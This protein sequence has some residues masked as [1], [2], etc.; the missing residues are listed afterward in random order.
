[1]NIYHDGN[2]ASPDCQLSWYA[3]VYCRCLERQSRLFLWTS[4]RWRERVR[5]A[6][7]RRQ[8]ERGRRKRRRVVSCSL[9]VWLKGGD[10]EQQRGGRQG[11]SQLEQR[12]RGIHREECVLCGCTRLPRWLTDWLCVFVCDRQRE[13]RTRGYHST[14]LD[15]FGITDRDHTRTKK[16]RIFHIFLKVVYYLFFPF[17]G[18]RV[19]RIQ[20]RVCSRRGGGFSYPRCRFVSARGARLMPLA[21]LHHGIPSSL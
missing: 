21:G 14:G 15:V 9:S 2:P 13:G 10:S 3:F 4:G 18:I 1:M 20:S 8:K 7:K 17:G 6:E 19:N 5:I 12:G 16:G 11:G